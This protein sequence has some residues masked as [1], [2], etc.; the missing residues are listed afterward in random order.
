M[1]QE[2]ESFAS[3]SGLRINSKK[4]AVLKIGPFRDTNAK[5]YTLKKLY[6]SPGPIRILG[7]FIHPDWQLM[8]HDNFVESLDKVKGI[9]GSWSNRSQTLVGKITV[10]NSLINTLFTHKF[11][12]LPSPPDTFFKTYKSLIIEYL[13]NGRTPRIVYHKLVQDHNHL[14]LKLVDLKSKDIALKAT[15]PIRWKE[16]EQSELAWFYAGLLIKDKRMWECN[17]DKKDLP[18]SEESNNVALSILKAWST[19]NYKPQMN[20]P[21]EILNT[22]L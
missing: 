14:G 18:K 1:L 20:T 11:L 15:W 8:Y 10:V 6:W 16:R 21:E 9:I 4:C 12:A 3:Y 13:W 7:M 19:I 5:F 22:P 2:L 17:L